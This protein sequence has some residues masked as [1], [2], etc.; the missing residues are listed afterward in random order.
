MYSITGCSK[1]LSPRS[2]IS[3]RHHTARGQHMLTPHECARGGGGRDSPTAW[4]LSSS[5]KGVCTSRLR[6]S[7]LCF[8]SSVWPNQ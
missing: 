3:A 1:L 5:G 6:Q 7:S 2:L 4:M 8:G